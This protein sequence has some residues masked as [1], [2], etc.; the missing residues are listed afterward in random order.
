MTSFQTSSYLKID[1]SKLG[2]YRHYCPKSYIRNPRRSLSSPYDDMFYSLH[3]KR[4]K[5]QPVSFD[6]DQSQLLC[7]LRTSPGTPARSLWLHSTSE[8]SPPYFR[9]AVH[10]AGTPLPVFFCAVD[11]CCSPSKPTIAHPAIPPFSL[12]L[13]SPPS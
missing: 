2:L 12:F 13:Y 8:A 6:H 4:S 11:R 5:S 10:A 9:E 3:R 1:L 7:F